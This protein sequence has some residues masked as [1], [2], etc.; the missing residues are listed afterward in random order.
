MPSSNSNEESPPTMADRTK[1][2]L[3][4]IVQSQPFGCSV[5][6]E[7]GIVYMEFPD[8]SILDFTESVSYRKLPD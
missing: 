1:S 5:K 6:S 2:L 8:G 7:Q 4:E 3:D